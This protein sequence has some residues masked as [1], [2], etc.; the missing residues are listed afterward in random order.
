[1]PLF[2]KNQASQQ[3]FLDWSFQSKSDWCLLSTLLLLLFFYFVLFQYS[4]LFRSFCMRLPTRNTT[5]ILSTWKK[6]KWAYKRC[7]CTDAWSRLDIQRGAC[8][9]N[10]SLLFVCAWNCVMCVCDT[11][12]SDVTVWYLSM[13]A[14]RIFTR[15]YYT[16]G[17]RVSQRRPHYAK[18]LIQNTEEIKCIYNFINYYSFYVLFVGGSVACG[19]SRVTRKDIAGKG[20]LLRIMLAAQCLRVC[21][22]CIRNWKT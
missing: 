15:L 18:L 8:I 16:R 12:K 3:R 22:D 1:M 21:A 19:M 11:L 7:A 4:H 10:T 9:W 14:T 17:S 13:C 2:G 5:I 6:I 20:A